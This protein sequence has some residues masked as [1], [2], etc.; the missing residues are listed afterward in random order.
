MAHRGPEA[1]ASR[2]DLSHTADRS[3]LPAGTP[4]GPLLGGASSRGS[5]S[6]A[7]V[8]QAVLHITRCGATS[9]RREV[10][11]PPEDLLLEPQPEILMMP[12]YRVLAGQGTVVDCFNAP[13]DTAASRLARE[14]SRGFQRPDTRF[15]SRS[16]LR[17][18]RLDGGRWTCVY[19]WVPAP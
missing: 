12:S 8:H 14:L 4:Y 2:R 13:D 18:E 7:P 6:G 16:D 10:R 17:V 1:P 11:T 5:G 3:D 9:A 15:G 19:A